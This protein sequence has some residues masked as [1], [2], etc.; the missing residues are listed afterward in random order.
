MLRSV[1]FI[2]LQTLLLVPLI[3][4]LCASDASVDVQLLIRNGLLKNLPA[5]QDAAKSLSSDQRLLIY[6]QN[7]KDPLLG[8]V[9]NFVLG[10]GIGSFVQ[11]DVTGGLIGLL[12]ELGSYGLIFPGEI[13]V[14]YGNST[15][16]LILV[17]VGAVS[18]ISFA[19]FQWVRPFSYSKQYNETLSD[20]LMNR[21]LSLSLNFDVRKIGLSTT[22][23]VFQVGL[24]SRF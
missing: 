6:E 15:P 1:K 2:L 7:K 19:I 16:G 18:L 5:I 3:G 11:S 21:K 13:L 17:V 8:F 12:G 4:P 23:E 22:E 14:I 20:A 9:L 10:F 24:V